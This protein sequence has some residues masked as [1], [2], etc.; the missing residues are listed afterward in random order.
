MNSVA[1]SAQQGRVCVTQVLVLLPLDLID[2]SSVLSFQ[3]LP[4]GG[5]HRIMQ[6]LPKDG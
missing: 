4:A 2:H 5:Y 3:E 1:L 6:S